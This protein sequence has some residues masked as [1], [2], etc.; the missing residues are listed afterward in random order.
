MPRG[1]VM[2]AVLHNAPA[3]RAGQGAGGIR[4]GPAN[5]GFGTAGDRALGGRA[6]DGRSDCG[7]TYCPGAIVPT[8]CTSISSTSKTSVAFGGI[9]PMPS[10]PYAMSGGITS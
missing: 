7:S 4:R 9:G 6:A 3:A 10:A 2:G 8:G 1:G 5:C